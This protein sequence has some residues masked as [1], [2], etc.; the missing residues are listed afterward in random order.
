MKKLIFITIFLLS[1]SFNSFANSIHF[2]DFDKV[3]NFSKAGGD[4]QKKLKKKFKSE[5]E[6]FVKQEQGIR[7]EESDLISQKKALAPEEYKKKVEALRKKVANL[8]KNK[9]QSFNSIAKSRSDARQSL[10][11]AV[12]P[13]IKKYMD[14]NKIQMVFDKQAVVMGD[15]TLEITDKIIAILNKNLVSLKIN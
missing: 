1:Y 8:Q 5:S 6:K 7:K 4:A 2:I 14:D 13:L 10:L 15:T 3:L 11:K 12:N 9:Q